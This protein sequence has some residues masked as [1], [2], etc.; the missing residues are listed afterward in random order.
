MSSHPYNERS[1]HALPHRRLQIPFDWVER[2]ENG[3]RLRPVNSSVNGS[4]E[5]ILLESTFEYSFHVM[6]RD[7]FLTGQAL[8]EAEE[9]F[10]DTTDE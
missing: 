3:G 9:L 1:R 7:G 6:Y 4:G 8:R 2:W 10:G 5:V